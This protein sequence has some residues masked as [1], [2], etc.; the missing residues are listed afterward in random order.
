MFL[1]K[2]KKTVAGQNNSPGH[3]QIVRIIYT[4]FENVCPNFKLNDALSVNSKDLHAPCF[5]LEPDLQS[6]DYITRRPKASLT[7][8]LNH[9]MGKCKL[10]K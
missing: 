8:I 2:K 3:L 7:V 6:K 4:N 5:N 9:N 1:V 10:G